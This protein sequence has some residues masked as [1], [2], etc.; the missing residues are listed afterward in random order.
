MSVISKL[1]IAVPAFSVSMVLAGQAQA[2]IVI[3]TTTG[4]N[5]IPFG[6][7]AGFPEYQQVYAAG[8]FSGPITIDDL[9]LYTQSGT[10]SP[11]TGT[12]TISLSTTSAVVNGLSTELSQNIGSNNTTVF[13]SKLP[14]I[15][16]GVLTI[17]FSTPFTY[18]PAQGN[19]LV[20][21]VESTPYTGGPSFEFDSASGGLFSRGYSD[22]T[23]PVNNDS[24]L[25]TGFTS[26][27]PLPSAL[28]L[29]L[30]GLGG[31]GAMTRK[32]RAAA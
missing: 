1:M 2:S 29:L 11:N 20:N 8:D 28:W 27:V 14:T 4:G 21:I 15:Q 7:I 32:V 31:L 12:F 17:P 16:N 24:G 26:P 19:L 13:N 18:N 10:G 23:I 22:Q 6:S 30:S 3:G 9:E 5:F 25:V